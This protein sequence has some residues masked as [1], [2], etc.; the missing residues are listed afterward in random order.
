MSPPGFPPSS[1]RVRR[2]AYHKKRFS[3][4]RL[5]S[6]TTATLPEYT[7]PPSTGTGHIWSAAISPEPFEQPPDYPDSAEEADEETDDYVPLSPPLSPRRHRRFRSVS[8]T[9]KHP[10]SN[11]SADLVSASDTFLDSLLERSV[12]AL[13]LSN[14][15]LQSSMSTQ[16]SLAT[17]LGGSDSGA[18]QLMESQARILTSRIRENRG[19]HAGWMDDLDDLAKG[20]E[21]L[22]GDGVKNRPDENAISRSLPTSGVP[23]PPRRNP[24]RPSLE[25]R[26]NVSDAPRL[27][28][29]AGD[30]RHNIPPPR[31]LTQYVSVESALGD[32]LESTADL[33]SIYLPSTIG[34]R[35]ASHVADLR[36]PA[37]RPPP[38]SQ[39]LA[40]NILSSAAGQTSP[41]RSSSPSS[42]VF[43]FYSPLGTLSH[44][45]HFQETAF[46]I[47]HAASGGT[48]PAPVK[49]APVSV[50]FTFV[51]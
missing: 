17:V 36:A 34:L 32:A 46:E 22:Y 48:P 12:H 42:Y 1:T 8:R 38:L 9:H 43:C 11:S 30:H 33:T 5:S 39:P 31:A 16:S 14:T 40:Y 4:A 35:A 28:M 44:R 27:H 29:S 13:E 37:H 19:V 7:S 2:D 45:P 51:V 15:L 6:D 24:R 23:L 50:I 25:L 26:R 49:T 41:S 47:Y 18:D 21:N 20:V 3:L 10:Y